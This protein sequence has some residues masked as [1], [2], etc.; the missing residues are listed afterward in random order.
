MGHVD[1]LANS[2]FLYC[3]SLCCIVWQ[4]LPIRV[5]RLPQYPQ[6]QPNCFFTASIHEVSVE[7]KF[8]VIWSWFTWCP[9]HHLVSMQFWA[10]NIGKM[11]N[12]RKMMFSLAFFWVFHPS[13]REMSSLIAKK[14]SLL[15]FCFSIVTLAYH[16]MPDSSKMT[17]IAVLGVYRHSTSDPLS[18][19]YWLITILRL[20]EITF[21]AKGYEHMQKKSSK[22]SVFDFRLFSL[23]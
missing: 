11:G 1:G 5:I 13:C 23:Y 6:I 7:K 3:I 16:Q 21:F 10:I 4:L 22:N 9:R 18:I 14:R 20:L 17:K 2:F 19:K 8:H 12:S 15:K